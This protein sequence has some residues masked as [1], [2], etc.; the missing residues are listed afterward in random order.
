MVGEDEEGFFHQ[1][2][3]TCAKSS[4]HG[5]ALSLARPVY[6]T[7]VIGDGRISFSQATAPVGYKLLVPRNIG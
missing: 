5:H 3:E 7:S 1:D 4:G 2:R 6:C